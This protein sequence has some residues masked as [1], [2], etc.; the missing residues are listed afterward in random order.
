MRGYRRTQWWQLAIAVIAIPV[1][2]YAFAEGPPSEHTGGFGEPTCTECHIGSAL[3]SGQGSVTITAP[4]SYVGGQTYQIT[5]RVAD[6]QR[7][8]AS[9]SRWGFEMSARTQGGQQA[10]TLAPSNSFTQ[11]APT[12]N[13]IQ[14]IEHTVTGTRP[15]TTLGVNFTFNWTAPDTS[16]GPVVMKP[17]ATPPTTAKRSWEIASMRRQ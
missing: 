1:L 3:N 5:V 2:I 12:F 10:G 4:A 9:T 8:S 13:G 15:G 17:P 11:L 16:A 7:T 6:P 14:Y